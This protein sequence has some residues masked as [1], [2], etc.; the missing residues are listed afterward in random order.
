MEFMTYGVILAVRSYD[1]RFVYFCGQIS[2]PWVKTEHKQPIL[3]GL[4]F[5]S[6]Q[7]LAFFSNP[8]MLYM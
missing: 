2:C 5:H 8:K 6:T 7:F 4:K 1:P 3:W